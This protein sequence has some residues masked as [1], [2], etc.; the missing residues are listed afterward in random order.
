MKRIVKILGFGRASN[1]DSLAGI[2]KRKICKQFVFHLFGYLLVRMAKR[3]ISDL[4]MPIQG[5]ILQN[6]KSNLEE[7]QETRRRYIHCA[8]QGVLTNLSSKRAAPKLRR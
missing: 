6:I 5:K 7:D 4:A 2:L 3:L 8:I 1:F